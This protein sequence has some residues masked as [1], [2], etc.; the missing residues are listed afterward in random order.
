MSEQIPLVCLGSGAALTD[1][2]DW[3]SLL[4]D[5][6]VLL[7]LP[8][9]TIPQLHRL[10]IDFSQIEHVFISHLH[11]DHMFGLPFL[12]L[13]YCVRLQRENPMY[14][15][16]PIGLKEITYQLCDLAWPD[17]RKVGFEPRLPLEFIEIPQEGDYQAGDL[18]FTATSMHH[19]DLDAFGYRFAYKGRTIGYTGDTGECAQLNHLLDK[20]D[21]AIIEL[22]HPRESNDPGHMDRPTFVELAKWLI[23]QGST[24]LATHM[25]ETPDPIP[26]VEICEDGKTYWI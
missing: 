21:V 5:G 11:A 14:I 1:G 17:L 23:A 13:E 9:T 8:P 10:D 6:R 4:I 16:G 25:S 26:G 20:V 18:R 7:D 15:I 24:I 22:T 2:R 12:L 19:F 3:S